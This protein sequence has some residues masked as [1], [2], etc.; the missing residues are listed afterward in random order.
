[1]AY[2]MSFM[3]LCSNVWLEALE[4]L[5]QSRIVQQESLLTSI[6][7][8]KRNE[9]IG[10]CSNSKLQ[11]AVMYNRDRKHLKNVIETFSSKALPYFRNERK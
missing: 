9:R 10:Y 3:A 7:T 8:D 11:G 6:T 2:I 5:H 1:M 4:R